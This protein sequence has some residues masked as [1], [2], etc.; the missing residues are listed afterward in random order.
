MFFLQYSPKSTPV[1]TSTS[2]A[3]TLVALF[4]YSYVDPGRFALE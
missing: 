3:A 1:T 2:R 4:E